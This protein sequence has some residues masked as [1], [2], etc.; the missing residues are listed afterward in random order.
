MTKKDTTRF[1]WRQ[2]PRPQVGQRVRF[3]GSRVC[4][5][6]AAG[7]EGEIV[8]IP[9]FWSEDP[10]HQMVHIRFADYDRMGAYN[11]F[12][13]RVAPIMRTIQ[14]TKVKQTRSG[15]RVYSAKR[16]K[17]GIVAVVEGPK[18]KMKLHYDKAGC[19]FPPFDCPI[20]LVVKT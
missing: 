6:L 2:I 12:L 11:W 9:K 3:L 4:L 17:T 7:S 18:G 19:F 16:T 8:R 20:D 10:N 15:K 5:G 13:W 14:V 1:D